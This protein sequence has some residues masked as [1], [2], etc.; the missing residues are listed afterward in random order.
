MPSE[1]KK[2]KKEKI[3]TCPSC[4]EEKKHYAKG[5][6]AN[7]YKVQSHRDKQG[8]QIRY[9]VI[10]G[11]RVYVTEKSANEHICSMC[12]IAREE[13][14]NNKLKKQML[15]KY[16]KLYKDFPDVVSEVVKPLWEDYL[17]GYNQIE[18]AK[19]NGTT[20][21]YVSDLIK[22]IK[23]K[24]NTEEQKKMDITSNLDQIMITMDGVDIEENNKKIS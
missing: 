22:R 15:F 7:C 12:R 4:G 8:T 21:Q 23:E 14:K 13:L 6:C 11:K 5:L 2:Q 17:S 3:I 1:T 9:C 18:V 19:R 20:R 16:R 10:C 24:L